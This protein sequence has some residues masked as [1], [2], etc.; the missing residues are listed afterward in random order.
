MVFFEFDSTR[1]FE[2]KSLYHYII[3]AMKIKLQGKKN[4]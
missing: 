4:K 2:F 3:Y 1:S